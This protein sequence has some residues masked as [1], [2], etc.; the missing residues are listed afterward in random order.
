ME[1]LS[2][3]DTICEEHQIPQM[4]VAQKKERLE[5][6]LSASFIPYQEE[7]R[8]CLHEKIQELKIAAD[9]DEYKQMELCAEIEELQ[10]EVQQ[11]QIHVANIQLEVRNAEAKA[12]EAENNRRKAESAYQQQ[13][14]SENQKKTTGGGCLIL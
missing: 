13:Q 7:F 1:A 6:L 12:Q 2:W 4:M 11:V 3:F 9:R 14:Q 8:E 5:I 10:K